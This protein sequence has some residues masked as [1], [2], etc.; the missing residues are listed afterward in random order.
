MA[1]QRLDQSSSPESPPGIDERR[2]R[3]RGEARRAILDATEELLIESGGFGFSIR[4][5]AKRCGYSAPLAD[6]IESVP[7]SGDPLSDLRE[8]LLVFVRFGATNPTFRRLMWSVSGKG[9]SRV[10]PAMERLRARVRPPLLELIAAGRFGD[11]DAETAGQ[12]IWALLHGLSS[13]Q[14]IEPE[15]PWTPQLGERAI[16]TL[17]RGM[18]HPARTEATR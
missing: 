15:H 1:L 17:L 4:S 5:L 11:I 7:E 8:L 12:L 14:V 10:T 2:E 16:D 3:H 6:E 13:I 18:T 9:E